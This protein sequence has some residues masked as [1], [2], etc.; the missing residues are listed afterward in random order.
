MD[1]KSSAA[2]RYAA[3][4][5]LAQEAAGG[6]R[7][8]TR[9]VLERLL[10]R[11]RTNVR[12]LVPGDRDQDDWVQLALLEILRS[13]GSFQGKSTLESW[14]D[15]IAVRTTMREVKTRRRHEKVVALDPDARPRSKEASSAR[16]TRLMMR[17][18][19]A[20]KLACLPENQRAV[21]VLR[22]VHGYSIAEIAEIVSAPPN[23]VRDRLRV[24]RKRLKKKITNDPMLKD[25]VMKRDS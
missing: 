21:V 6:D 22:L 11:V 8:A 16:E 10:D 24:G 18:Q 12:Y 7:G 3:D 17:H 13:L 5:S 14:S 25:W 9:Q 19:L 15:R 2:D 20:L 1:R 23:T 4:L